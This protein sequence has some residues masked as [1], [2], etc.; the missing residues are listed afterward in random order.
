MADRASRRSLPRPLLLCLALAALVVLAWAGWQIG[1]QGGQAEVA[2]RPAL[3]HVTGH[4]REAYLFG[5]VHALQRGTTWLS[6]E[7]A[8]AT[9]RSDRLILEVTGLEKERRSRAVF[10]RLGR[11]TGLA[12]ATA[13]LGPADAET[14]RALIRRRPGVLHGLDGYESWAAALLVSAAASAELGLSS[15]DGGETVLTRTFETAGK[16][17]RGLETIEEQLGIFDALPEADQRLLLVQAVREADAAASLHADLQQAW[18]Q[19][20]LDRMERQFLAPLDSAPRLRRALIDARNARWGAALDGDLRRHQGIAFVAV[21]A[22]HLLGT[23]S[24]Q[25]ELSRRGWHVRRVQ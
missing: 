17:V 7:I 22:G 14:L 10:E 6:P 12:P 9:A 19:G 18:A 16:P 15:E 21:G 13:R 24:L 11:A 1:R 2:A 20:D 25:N 5:T 3:W 4:G 8:R 23:A